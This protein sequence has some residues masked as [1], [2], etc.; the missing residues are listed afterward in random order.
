MDDKHAS[1]T[2]GS[3]VGEAFVPPDDPGQL[4]RNRDVLIERAQRH[5]RAMRDACVER[6]APLLAAALEAKHVWLF[7]SVARREATQGSDADVLVEVGGRFADDRFMD[8]MSLAYAARRQA[9]LPFSCDIVT[10]SSEEIA[11]KRK[12]ENPFFREIWKEKEL[13]A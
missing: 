10:L 4:T 5:S 3:A 8:R 11:D 7:G 9:R 6:L 1:N 2:L 12:A 13:I